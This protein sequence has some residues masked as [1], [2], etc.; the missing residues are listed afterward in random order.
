MDINVKKITGKLKSFSSKENISLHTTDLHSHIIPF[1]DDGTKSLDESIDII[2]QLKEL[3]F[4]K[5]ITTPHIMSHRFKN[6][7]KTIFCGYLELKN[8]LIRLDIDMDIQVAAEYY[9]DEYFLE[10]ID[11]NEILTFGDNYLLFELSYTVKPFMLEQAVSKL[12]N[13][14]YKPILAHPE[15]YSYY[16][17]EQDYRRLKEQGLY[18][19]INAI[20]ME[21]FYGKK[22]KKAVENIID[23]GLVDF[24]GSDIHSQKYLDSFSKSIKSKMYSKL[25]SKNQ[26]KND[27]L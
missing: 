25:I 2:L 5:I 12:L 27:Y 4:K 18:F 11:K 6:T 20:S 15:R 8:E 14:G 21:G 7:K 24:I 19:Q 1:I 17:S 13:A 26:I 3:G 23:L 9:Y 10:L 16:N 22:V